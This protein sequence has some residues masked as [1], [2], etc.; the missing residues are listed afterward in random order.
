[1]IFL[2][3]MQDLFIVGK[4][5]VDDLKFIKDANM[6]VTGLIFIGLFET[7]SSLYLYFLQTVQLH[8]KFRKKYEVLDW[9]FINLLPDIQK[10]KCYLV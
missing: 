7:K 1:M 2:L 9:Y 3:M 6:G 4:F 5:T 8:Y 10:L